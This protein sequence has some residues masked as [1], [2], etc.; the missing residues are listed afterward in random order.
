M[1]S[2]VNLAVPSLSDLLPPERMCFVFRPAPM[3]VSVLQSPVSVRLPSR[4]PQLLAVLHVFLGLTFYF[5]GVTKTK[6]IHFLLIRCFSGRKMAQHLPRSYL[7]RASGGV[8][9]F[10]A[11]AGPSA[12]AAFRG[13]GAR[14]AGAAPGARPAQTW[15]PPGWKEAPAVPQA[16]GNE[17]SS[18]RKASQFFRRGFTFRTP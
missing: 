10:G 9:T 13:L 12:G 11:T 15:R 3:H 18:V 7:P 8:A 2:T 6:M 14:D 16:R 1:T 4:F 5:K 17:H